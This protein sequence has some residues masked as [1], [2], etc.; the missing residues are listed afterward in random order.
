M[1]VSIITLIVFF[2]ENVFLVSLLLNIFFILW[3]FP[4]Y[5]LNKVLK[6]KSLQK[7]LLNKERRA[8][9][10]RSWSYLKKNLNLN[11]IGLLS[12]K[13]SVWTSILEKK[14]TFG[15]TLERYRLD[16]TLEATRLLGEEARVLSEK[17]KL[18]AIN[19][20]AQYWQHRPWQDLT[21]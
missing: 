14:H 2:Y 9:E 16:T 18:E 1:T 13:L 8:D 17:V 7:E 4:I 6:Y 3:C 19:R 21:A 15:N 20:S 11:I 12:L 10:S 5:I